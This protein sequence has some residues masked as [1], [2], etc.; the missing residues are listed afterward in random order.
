[1]R[2]LLTGSAL[3]LWLWGC[4]S[5][6]ALVGNGS[7][8]TTGIAIHVADSSGRPIPGARIQLRPA[9][10][11]RESDGS[12]DPVQA[13]AADGNGT[14]WV[15]GLPAGRWSVLAAGDA[16]QGLTYLDKGDAD[17]EQRIDLTLRSSAS[18]EGRIVSLAQATVMVEGLPW[19]VRTDSTGAFRI[20]G[21]PAGTL[22]LQAASGS[23]QRA[24]TEIRTLPGLVSNAGTLIVTGPAQETGWTDSVRFTLETGTARSDTLLGYPLLVRLSDTA[25]DFGKT[26]GGDLRFQ[27]GDAVLSHEVV[28][29]DPVGRTA[30][31]W[32]RLDTL[33]PSDTRLALQLRY[34]GIGHPDRSD[35]RAV[36]ADQDGWVG[37]WHL[38]GADPG[39]DAVGRLRATDWRTRDVPGLAGRARFCDTG[40]LRIGDAAA[41]HLQS[42]TLSCWARRTGSQITVGKL[43]SKGNLEDWHNTWSLQTFD[44][45]WRMGFLSLR[46]DSLRDTLHAASRIPDG[47]WT[48]VTATWDSVSGIQRFYVDGVPTDSSV[49]AR[50]FDYSNRP[51]QDMDLFLG[52]NFIGAIDEPRLSRRSRSPAWIALDAATQ[53][54]NSSALRFQRSP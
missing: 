16:G 24:T 10:W 42:L 39:A 37:A 32:V 30:T 15:H 20:D 33:L 25:I 17:Q 9:G 1:M 5:N 28:Q 29:W 26:D 34:G 36:F 41:L 22:T 35:S 44:S 46:V 38:E 43:V 13:V 19:S 14:A 18:L 7:E 53:R 47:A 31:V 27:R 6:E 40:W 3:A 52:A 8:T 48:L 51:P 45:T 21:L 11:K 23:V 49:Q 54:P 2:R 50:A 12:F 4:G